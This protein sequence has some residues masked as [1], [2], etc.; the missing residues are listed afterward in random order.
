MFSAVNIE[1]IPS[2][3]WR[4]K[5]YKLNNTGEWND[6]GTGYVQITKEVLKYLLI[7]SQSIN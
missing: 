4:V 6:Y 3:K 2:T 7:F 1:R 5:Y